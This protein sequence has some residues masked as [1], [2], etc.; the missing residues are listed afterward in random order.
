M[1]LLPKDQDWTAYAYLVYLLY[2][3]SVPFVVPATAWDRA[4]ALASTMVAL[5]LYFWG[6]WLRGRRALWVI[7]AFVL[8]GSALGRMNPA[9]SVFFVYGASFLGKAFEARAAYGFLGGLLA[10]IGL[11]AWLLQ[12]QAF[13]WIP[14]LV[15][16]ALIGSVVIQQI[17]SKRLT[18]KLL[19]AQEE[20]EHLAKTAERE[21]IARDLHDL[22]GHTLSVIILKSELASR[23]GEKDPARAAREIRDVERISR[24]AL[25]QVRSAVRGYRSA[26]LESELREARATLETA[27]IQVESSVAPPP[28]SPLQESVFALALRE[29]VTNVVRHANATACRLSLLQD[30]G[31]C[32]MEIADNGCGG[33]LVEGNGLSGMRQRVEALGGKLERDGSQGTRLRIRVPV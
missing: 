26:G 20:T 2:Y 11:E 7:G 10:L 25:A 13:M 18:L 27:G 14:G 15:F 31:F 23:L 29:A 28:L 24:E 16:T 8:L 3:A 30:G 9:A 33:A 19:R 17:H 5:P 21:R 1:R 6:Y 12:W 4:V 22:L 32:Q